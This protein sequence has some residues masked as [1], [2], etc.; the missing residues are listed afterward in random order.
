MCLLKI[1]SMGTCIN[2]VIVDN[3]NIRHLLSE[4]KILQQLGSSLMPE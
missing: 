1:L 3:S 4:I 2:M